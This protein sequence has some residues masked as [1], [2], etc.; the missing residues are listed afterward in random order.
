MKK[1]LL[2]SPF[3][4]PERIST[5]LF[6]TKLVE[7]LIKKGVVVDVWCSHPFIRCGVQCMPIIQISEIM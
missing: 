6:N 5:G 1:V 7:G 2:V 3:F 4:H